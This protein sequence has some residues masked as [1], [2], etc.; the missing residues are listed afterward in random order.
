[1]KGFRKYDDMTLDKLKKELIDI[2]EVFDSLCKKYDIK[3]FAT[4]GTLLGV[5]RHGGFIPWDD[6][7][8][9]GMLRTE[10]DKFLKIPHSEFEGY[11]LC[12]PEI[13]PGGYYS[14]V[15]KFYK[16]D[17]K[18]ITPISYADN[19]NDMGIF[20]ELFPFDDVEENL[21]EKTKEES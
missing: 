1:M 14:F 3:Y 13:T 8:D 4:G 2:F 18:F 6:D 19:K 7:L 5:V 10:Y 11:G 20:I 12:A 15:T 9:I 16:K 17:T 21:L